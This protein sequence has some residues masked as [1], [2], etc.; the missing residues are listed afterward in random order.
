MVAGIAIPT[1][2]LVGPRRGPVRRPQPEH[3]ARRPQDRDLDVHRPL[4]LRRDAHDHRLLLPRPRLQLDLAVGARGVLRPMTLALSNGVIAA[5]IVFLVLDIFAVIFGLSFAAGGEGAEGRGRRRAGAHP[6]GPG[7]VASRL[8]PQVAAD[9]AARVRRAV[10]RSDHRVPVAEPEGRVRFG[11]QRRG[12]ER[13]QVAA[14]RR[15]RVQRRRPVL[16]RPLERRGHR[17]RRLPGR[18]GHHRRDHAAVPA[19]R[20]PGMPRAV[21]RVRRSGSSARAT[22]PSTT[23]PA[24]TSSVRR[25][26]AWTAS[27]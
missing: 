9:L 26:A 14:G 20:A 8:L 7:H 2:I 16:H 18:A 23:S 19:V 22:A 12:A 3:E 11:D 17:R 24:S 5:I 10:R 6:A 13:H 25:R 1:F 4:L 15:A 21:L 27:W